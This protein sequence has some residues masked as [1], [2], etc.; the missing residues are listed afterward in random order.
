M[1]I[2]IID[3]LTEQLK[4]ERKLFL[5]IFSFNLLFFILGLALGYDVH[6]FADKADTDGT[7]YY[8][9]ALDPFSSSPEESG[10]RHATFLYPLITYLI[11]QGNPFATALTMELIN[12]TAVSYTHLTLPTIYS[13]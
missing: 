5:L 1:A 9:I 12:I 8:N 7:S 2:Q 3:Y 10:F 13:V 11:A 4:D 6:H